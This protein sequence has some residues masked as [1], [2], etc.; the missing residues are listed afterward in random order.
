M[1][2]GDLTSWDLLPTVSSQ[3]NLQSGRQSCLDGRQSCVDTSWLAQERWRQQPGRGML[4]RCAVSYQNI[5]P[6]GEIFNS[7]SQPQGSC[8]SD[9]SDSS[10]AFSAP[11]SGLTTARVAAATTNVAWLV[12][13]TVTAK[14]ESAMVVAERPGANMSQ[15]HIDIRENGDLVAPAH[16]AVAPL[17]AGEA[18]RPGGYSLARSQT[19]S[20]L[21]LWAED[22]TSTESLP[23]ATAHPSYAYQAEQRADSAT[24]HAEIGG[25]AATLSTRGSLRS[26]IGKRGASKYI[27]SAH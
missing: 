1:T 6:S 24:P 20:N 12:G 3:P 5:S 14:K 9:S 13:A 19:V 15:H 18:G 22:L 10:G 8:S 11:E 17:S 25:T 23:Q 21:P 16:L 4:T 2:A 7:D 27:L 26:K